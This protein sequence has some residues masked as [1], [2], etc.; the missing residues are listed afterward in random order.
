MAAG[1]HFMIVCHAIF[2][3]FPVLLP[4]VADGPG[5]SPVVL[6]VLVNTVDKGDYFLQMTATGDVLVSTEDFS[7]LGL[8]LPTSRAVLRGAHPACGCGRFISTAFCW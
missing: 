2:A 8:Q 5:P 3:L 7:K 1:M 6:R 4:A